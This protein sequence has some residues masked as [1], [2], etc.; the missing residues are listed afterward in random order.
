M[1]SMLSTK[2]PQNRTTQKDNLFL[3]WLL[4]QPRDWPPLIYFFFVDQVLNVI[5]YVLVA[6]SSDNLSFF[7]PQSRPDNSILNLCSRATPAADQRHPAATLQLRASPFFVV[8]LPCAE[9]K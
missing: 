2:D 6:I 5:G 9:S 4:S 7:L 3:G 8:V 1:R